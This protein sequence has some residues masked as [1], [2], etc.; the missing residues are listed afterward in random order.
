M[1]MGTMFGWTIELMTQMGI[2]QPLVAFIGCA[3]TV[4]TAVVIYRAFRG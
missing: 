1:D 4:S 3:L 2:L